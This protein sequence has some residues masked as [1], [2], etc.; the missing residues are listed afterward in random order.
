MTIANNILSPFFTIHTPREAG[1]R[2]SAVDLNNVFDDPSAD[3]T[4]G[5]ELL[6]QLKTTGVAETQVSTGVDHHINLI[7]KADGALPILVARR[8]RRWGEHGRYRR[9]QGRT[10]SS[11][12]REREEKQSL[13]EM[14]TFFISNGGLSLELE[15]VYH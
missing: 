8:S 4:A 10:R 2:L 15:T 11:H 3:W 9:T 14:E 5:I 6:L 13:G 1:V 7:V 12:C